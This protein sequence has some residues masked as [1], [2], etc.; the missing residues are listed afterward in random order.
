MALVMSILLLQHMDWPFMRA[1]E[2]YLN[3]A[4]ADARLERWQHYYRWYKGIEYTS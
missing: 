3:F 2:A 1:A 4:E